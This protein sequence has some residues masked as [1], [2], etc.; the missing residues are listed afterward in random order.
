MEEGAGRRERFLSG[1]GGKAILESVGEGFA[2]LIQLMIWAKLWKV[3][4]RVDISGWV[5]RED[6]L[7]RC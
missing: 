7:G 1:D 2:F 3:L 5:F 4:S 6:F